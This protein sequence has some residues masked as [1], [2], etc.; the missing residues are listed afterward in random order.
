[1]RSPLVSACD[2]KRAYDGDAGPNTGG[3]GSYSPVEFWTEEL[4]H[5]VEKQV[6]LPAIEGM[7]KEGHPYRGALYGGLA[8]TED[9]PKVI[10]FNARLGDPEAQVILPRLDTDLVDIMQAIAEGNLSETQISWNNRSC[11]AVAVA[12]G[13]YPQSYETGFE[14]EGIGCSEETALV[15]H[16]GTKLDNGKV[17]TDGGRVLT[18]VGQGG[19]LAEARQRAYDAVKRIRFQGSFYRSDIAA[20]PAEMAVA[21]GIEQPN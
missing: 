2:Y 12:S 4:A 1:M 10:E 15:F 18:V 20:L 21:S 8:M 3:M 7:A 13:G 19:D 9:G 16:A 14:I 6:I 17:L 5:R 11:V